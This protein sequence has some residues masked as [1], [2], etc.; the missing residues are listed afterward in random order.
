MGR[1]ERKK[2]IRHRQRLLGDRYTRALRGG[3]I[4]GSEPPSYTA[5]IVHTEYGYPPEASALMKVGGDA[6]LQ[7]VDWKGKDEGVPAPELTVPTDWLYVFGPGA[8][9]ES[10]A[11]GPGEIGGIPWDQFSGVHFQAGRYWYVLKTSVESP[12]TDQDYV[13]ALTRNGW[14]VSGKTD[15]GWT[16]IPSTPIFI[17]EIRQPPEFVEMRRGRPAAEWLRVSMI[18][19]HPKGARWG[20]SVALDDPDDDDLTDLDIDGHAFPR[21]VAVETPSDKTS[22]TAALERAEWVVLGETST[23]NWIVEPL[24]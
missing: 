4:T 13:D 10:P 1:D 15:N 17:A 21:W 20:P 11:G 6:T 9:Q 16:V 12:R 7:L 8:V 23:G 19:N 2:A 22:Y 24:P 5:R 3:P 14:W 18:P